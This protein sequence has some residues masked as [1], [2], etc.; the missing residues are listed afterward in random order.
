MS[1][2]DCSDDEPISSENLGKELLL[3]A[4]Y[5]EEEDL[6]T[7]LNFR[8]VEGDGSEIFVDVNYKDS[9]S[10]NTAFHY[11]SANGHVGCLKLLSEFGAKLLE[12]AEGSSPVHWW[13]VL[14][15]FTIANNLIMSAT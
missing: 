10:G 5:G 11:A 4:R 14:V 7:I 1:G 6:R 8:Q 13:I 3:C 12:N 9:E 15:F 2:S